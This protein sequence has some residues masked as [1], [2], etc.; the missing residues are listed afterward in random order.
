MK[1][2][3]LSPR[4]VQLAVLT[5]IAGLLMAGCSGGGDATPATPA[6]GVAPPAPAVV[7]SD[8]PYCPTHCIAVWDVEPLGNNATSGIR[9]SNQ[10]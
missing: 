1:Q 4:R 10:Q 3:T 5:V 2:I 8:S 7:A 6:A 9:S